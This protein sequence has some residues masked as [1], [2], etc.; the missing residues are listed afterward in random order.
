MA[1]YEDDC[2]LVAN[3]PTQAWNK[4]PVELNFT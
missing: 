4:Q 1:D 2:A 3:T